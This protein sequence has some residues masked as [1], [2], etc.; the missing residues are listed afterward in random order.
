MALI[1]KAQARKLGRVHGRQAASWKFDGNTTDAT[2]RAVL[3]GIEGYDAAILDTFRP[4]SWLSGEWAG[5]S[6]PELLGQAETAREL[7]RLEGVES[8][9]EQAAEHAYWHEL[10]LTARANVG[11]MGRKGLTR[12]PCHN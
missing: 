6:I 4:P 5:E 8:A 9:Y 3:R 2:Y 7:D 1:T 11:M 12:C 10:E